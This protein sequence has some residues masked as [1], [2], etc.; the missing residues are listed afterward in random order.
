MGRVRPRKIGKAQ[1]DNE[2]ERERDKEF[3]ERIEVSGIGTVCL[4]RGDNGGWGFGGGEGGGG[5][6]VKK[7]TYEVQNN[8]KLNARYGINLGSFLPWGNT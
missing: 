3:P 2:T 4:N 5:A 1:R 6:K 7:G 8:E